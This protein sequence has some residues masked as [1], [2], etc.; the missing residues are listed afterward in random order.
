MFLFCVHQDTLY[1]NQ[2]PIN[3]IDVEWIPPYHSQLNQ[4]VLRFQSNMQCVEFVVDSINKSLAPFY[5]PTKLLPHSHLLLHLFGEYLLQYYMA[6][7]IF[8][9]YVNQ[10]HKVFDPPL[11][12]MHQE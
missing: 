9:H 2:I 6:Y 12:L 1:L 8:E 4:W 5:I 11:L 3:H 7:N 10:W